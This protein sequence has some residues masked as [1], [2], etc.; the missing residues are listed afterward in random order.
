MS[1]NVELSFNFS[2]QKLISYSSTYWTVD[3]WTVCHRIFPRLLGFCPWDSGHHLGWEDWT[4]HTQSCSL[5]PPGFIS[6]LLPFRA[7]A[8]TSCLWMTM[9]TMTYLFILCFWGPHHLRVLFQLSF[10]WPS[11]S[12]NQLEQPEC[13]RELTPL[14]AAFAHGL[15]RSALKIPRLSCL[16]VNDFQRH[17]CLQSQRD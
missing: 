4:L 2:R 5:P 11:G 12:F 15:T 14:W 1:W 16:S 6:P 3:S 10:Q 8:L 13:A 17:I 9:K 7:P